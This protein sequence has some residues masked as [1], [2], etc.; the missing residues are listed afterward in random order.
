VTAAILDFRNF[1]IVMVENF[2]RAKLRHCAKFRADRSNRCGSM[3]IFYFQDGGRRV[4]H[5]QI[6]EILTV[7][8]LKRSK[9]HYL[10]KFRRSRSNRARDMTIF[11]FSKMA[12]AAILDF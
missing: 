5:F 11:R 6:L 3:T 8:T 2:K 9:R 12:A 4:L 10:A 7:G 1:K